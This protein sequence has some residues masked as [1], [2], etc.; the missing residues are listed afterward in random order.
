MF[1]SPNPDY[2]HGH[3]W[4]TAEWSQD[5]F[6][7]EGWVWHMATVVVSAAVLIMGKHWSFVHSREAVLFQHSFVV[8]F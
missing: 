3:S 8:Q 5:T 2:I 6:P 4:K 1:E 7:R